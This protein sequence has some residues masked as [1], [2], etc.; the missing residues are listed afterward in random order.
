MGVVLEKLRE[1]WGAAASILTLVFAV[2]CAF[3]QK[4]SEISLESRFFLVGLGGALA[5][6]F[7]T[8]AFCRK[9]ERLKGSDPQDAKALPYLS[10]LGTPLAIAA[11]CMLTILLL[12]ET[13]TFH[14]VRILQ[15][16]YPEDAN[17]GT[18]EVQ[19]PHSPVSLVVRLSVPQSGPI[20]LEEV[21][22]SWN[23]DDVAQWRMENASR[24]GVTLILS[25]FRSPQV[26]GV[27]YRLSGEARAMEIEVSANPAEVRI[28]NNHQLSVFYRNFWIFGGFLCVGGLLYWLFLLHSLRA[29]R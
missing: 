6:I 5:V 20:V 26:F 17:A 29:G 9:S 28:L 16:D 1:Y 2:V 24:H 25:G 3:Q 22:G 27:W 13:A 4:F 21:P 23:R 18:I 12:R 11:F 14:N 10:W 8:R 15:Q 7:I 19:P